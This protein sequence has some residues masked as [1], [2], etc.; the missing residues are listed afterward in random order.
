MLRSHD[1]LREEQVADEEEYDTS[2]HEDG[3]CNAQRDAPRMT[4]PCDPKDV[5]HD[6]REAKSEDHAV[7][8]E[9][10]VSLLI[11]LEEHHM[12]SSCRE[13]D[14]Q[15]DSAYWDVREDR[16]DLAQS[17]FLG[18]IWPARGL[19][20]PGLGKMSEERRRSM[21]VTSWCYT[22]TYGFDGRHGGVC[23]AGA[24]RGMVFT[25]ESDRRRRW[26][27]GRQKVEEG[28]W[29]ST[30]VGLSRSPLQGRHPQLICDDQPRWPANV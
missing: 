11:A 9:F 10:L 7:D 27:C 14:E 26:R 15:K 19:R 25:S 18:T 1:A 24:S 16:W 2:V 4:C 17:L 20:E 28:A 12:A 21:T 6:P 3:S 8:D 5:S 22:C 23:E 30:A 29:P 13:E